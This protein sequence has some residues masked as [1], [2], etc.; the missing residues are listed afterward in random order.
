MRPYPPICPKVVDHFEK[1]NLMHFEKQN[2]APRA[3]YQPAEGNLRHVRP[4]VDKCIDRHILH[5]VHI[6]GL[7]QRSDVIK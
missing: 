3:K 7:L 4:Q 6:Y 5:N 1:Q 2:Y